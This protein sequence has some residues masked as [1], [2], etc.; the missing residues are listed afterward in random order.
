MR[1]GSRYLLTTFAAV[2]ALVLTG[3]NGGSSDVVGGPPDTA[4]GPSLT[5]VGYAVPKNGWDA[6]GTAFA[7]TE[8]GDGT[9]IDI[10]HSTC[11]AGLVPRW[12]C[13]GCGDPLDGGSVV[14]G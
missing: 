12:R 3:C 9:A 2:G 5:L 7:A 11:G 8:D 13:R 1:H 14:V 6:I 10:V 4:S